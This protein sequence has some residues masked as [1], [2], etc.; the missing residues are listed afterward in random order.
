MENVEY[1]SQLGS[2]IRNNARCACDIK[3]RISIAKASEEDSFAGKSDLNLMK[4]IS[5][6]YI[7]SIALYG[8]KPRTLRKVDQN[9]HESFEMWCWR[10]MG[11]ISVILRSTYYIESG[12][13]NST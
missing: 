9:Y 2:Q 3:S 12:R 1:F 10:R 7:W 4:E 13:K 11:N 8:A 5:K 6:C